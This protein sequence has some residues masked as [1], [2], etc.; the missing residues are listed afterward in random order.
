MWFL[1]LKQKRQVCIQDGT[2]VCVLSLTMASAWL[3]WGSA[4]CFRKTLKMKH[5]SPLQAS[6]GIPHSTVGSK[7]AINTFSFLPSRVT[8]NFI[9]KHH[10]MFVL[11]INYRPNVWEMP[12]LS[13]KWQLAQRNIGRH[14]LCF[15]SQGPFPSFPCAN[16]LLSACRRRLVSIPWR[17][18][19]PCR[20]MLFPTLSL[21]IIRNKNL[22]YLY[23]ITR[24][25]F[26]Q[27]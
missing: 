26:K 16:I 14:L 21:F 24:Y 22:K 13:S 10:F 8:R 5:M 3:L 2:G 20:C 9:L 6:P 25:I 17:S 7:V 18:L 1:N 19:E 4:C 23:P 27:K 11:V 12:V 15:L